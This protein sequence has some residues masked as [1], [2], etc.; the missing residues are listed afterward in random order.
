MTRAGSSSSFPD[1]LVDRLAPYLVWGLWAAM[2]AASMASGVIAFRLHVS[3]PTWWQY[4]GVLA[5][6]VVPAAG[7]FAFILAVWRVRQ[8]TR[9]ADGFFPLVLLNPLLFTRA[10]NPFDSTLL[11]AGLLGLMAGAIIAMKRNN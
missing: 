2:A 9:L 1:A 7:T 11:A 4:A 6:G 10:V 3:A 5:N 8:R